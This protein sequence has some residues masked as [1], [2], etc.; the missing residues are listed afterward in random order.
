MNEL[1]PDDGPSLRGRPGR[2]ILLVV[3]LALAILLAGIALFTSLIWL[4]ASVA[5]VA[6]IVGVYR[7][8]RTRRRAP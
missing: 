1:P 4:A 7:W 5:I 3:I 8:R 2:V 6:I